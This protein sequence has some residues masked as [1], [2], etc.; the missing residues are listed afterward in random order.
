M[1]EVIDAMLLYLVII[2]GC[3][4]VGSVML[5]VEFLTVRFSEVYKS[6]AKRKRS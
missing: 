2:T 4:V 3:A 1:N 5:A 6:W